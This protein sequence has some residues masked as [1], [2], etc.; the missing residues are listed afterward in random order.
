[1]PSLI[2]ALPQ[3]G[4]DADSPAPKNDR[5]NT[6]GEITGDPPP[7]RKPPVHDPQR[8][9]DLPTDRVLFAPGNRIITPE[10]VSDLVESYRAISQQ[11]PGIV[12]CH[13]ERLGIYYAADGNR[14]LMA[15]RIIGVPFR[16][17]ILDH[18]PTQKELRRIR[19]TANNIRKAMTADQIADELRDHIAETGDTQESAAE[20]FG[21]SPGYV[22]KLLAP[23]K[24]LLS[25]LQDLVANPH[26]K[27]DVLRIIATMPSEDLQRK[28]AERVRQDIATTGKAKRDAI[29]RYADE[30]KGKKPTKEKPLVLKHEGVEVTFRKPNKVGIRAFVEKLV[31]A[32]KKVRDGDDVGS[33][34]T[35]F[36]TG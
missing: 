2:A 18:E 3:W 25:E 16:A 6:A 17:I 20:F 22:S 27:R 33:L 8:V 28:V 5:S 29:Q 12:Y 13:P 19:L 21:I 24:R 10:S 4:D 30:L 14:R 23:F 15:S 36:Q 35:H 26:V 7:E 1:M 32:L 9:Y 31:T 34:K 11:I